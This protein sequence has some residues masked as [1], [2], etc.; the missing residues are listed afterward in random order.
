MILSVEGFTGATGELLFLWFFDTADNMA[1]GDRGTQF[2]E[3]SDFCQIVWVL[4]N[5]IGFR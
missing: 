1:I 2:G 5:R 3:T 4:P